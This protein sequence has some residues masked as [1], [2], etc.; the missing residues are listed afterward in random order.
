MAKAKKDLGTLVVASKV[1]AL[2][3]QADVRTSKEAIG[4]YSDAVS[5]LVDRATGEATK[6]GRKT[7]SAEHVANALKTFGQEE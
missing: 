1:K 6:A 7:I 4:A 5:K 3:A 2:A